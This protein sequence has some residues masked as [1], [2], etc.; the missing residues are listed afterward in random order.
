MNLKEQKIGENNYII[1]V[2]KG[3]NWI[4][5]DDI[6]ESWKNNKF[7]FPKSNSDDE[8][9]FRSAQLGALYAIKSHWTVSSKAATIVMPTGTGKTEVMIATVVSECCSKTCIIVPSDLLR[10]QTIK[11]FSTL[12]KLREIGA[13]NESFENPIVGCLMSSPK[14]ITEL[15]ELL[16]RSNL[17]ITTMSLLNSGYF[18]NELI[19]LLAST[20]DTVI[21]D[22]AHHVPANS[23][24]KVKN[25]FESVKCL[26][27]TA[28]PFRN[29]GKKID[30][31]IIYNFP[32]GL[33]Q[34]RGYFKPINFYP[35]YEFD[36]DKKDL[37]VAKKAVELLESDIANGLPH[38][39]LVRVSSQ[40]RAKVL[41]ENIYQK[42]YSQ[43]APV[44]IISSN[45]AADNRSALQSVTDG[46][47]RI[48]VCVDMFSEGID[49]PQLKICAIHD[50]YKSLP[51]TIQFA[52]QE[53]TANNR[54]LFEL[55]HCKYSG[56]SQAG[57]RVG[58]LYEVC[59]QAEKCI[60]WANDTKNMLE[61]LTKRESDRISNGK[62]TRFEVGDNK[63]MF[64]L[65]NK[66]KLYSSVFS[67]FIVQPGVDSTQITSAM[68]Q[69]L[70]SAEAYLK[71][72]YG[73][74]LTLICS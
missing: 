55:Y 61:R 34:E 73:I 74:P 15:Q 46:I 60:K 66:L 64:M 51:I 62:P 28:T 14:D 69:V 8:V 48:I 45:S 49:I 17:I 20:C 71:D 56:A 32:L 63:V 30:G 47:S 59:G 53:D 13:I 6:V 37:S 4:N 58:D 12:G 1:H 18:K 23:W 67:V 36:S 16:D 21:I 29:D 70:C 26:Q 22:E 2:A 44:L 41:Y 72:T 10:K 50:K 11:R 68:H 52:V 42:Y 39:L 33:A 3:S 65:K 31:D 35:V 40:G 25:A 5:V 9:G 57:A 54:L 19:Q 43:Y 24:K 7:C 27:F 38:L